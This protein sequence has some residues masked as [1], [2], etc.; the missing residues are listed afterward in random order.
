LFEQYAKNTQQM[1]QSAADN[2]SKLLEVI[3][4]LFTYV[5]DPYS[6]KQKV[7]VNPKLT[8]EL[9]QKCIEK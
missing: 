9:L 2:Q 1:I 3:N 7:R 5:I 8:E 4:D 6:G